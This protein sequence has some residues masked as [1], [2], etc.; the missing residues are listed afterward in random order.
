MFPP[1]SF[2]GSY[3]ITTSLS[4]LTLRPHSIT[5]CLLADH[6]VYNLVVIVST[7]WRLDSIVG[8]VGWGGGGCG[9]E[10]GGG[11]GEGG[12]FLIRGRFGICS[13][14]LPPPPRGVLLRSQASPPLPPS[15]PIG[16]TFLKILFF[17]NFLFAHIAHTLAVTVSVTVFRQYLCVY[18]NLPKILIPPPK[19]LSATGY[20]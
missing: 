5:I 7:A 1:S 2:Q 10:W 6:T 3:N 12:C 4:P 13:L 17:N 19:S 8:G 14:P 18:T 20:S 11:G 9:V 15:D 16:H